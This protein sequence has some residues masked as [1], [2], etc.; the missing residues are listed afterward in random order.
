MRNR[1]DVALARV[2]ATTTIAIVTIV[3]I[4][5]VLSVWLSH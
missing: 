4:A 1:H 3:G 5:A 2:R